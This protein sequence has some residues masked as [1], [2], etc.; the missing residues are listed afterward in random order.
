MAVD[1]YLN[2]NTKI[3]TKG[4]N[5]GTKQI[6]NSIASMKSMLGKFGVAVS[7][8]F[9]DILGSALDAEERYV[10]WAVVDG[11]VVSLEFGEI[12]VL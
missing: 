3:N 9:A 4:F 2:F 8:A 1:G 5:S 6:S 10:L 12:V 11:T 7:S